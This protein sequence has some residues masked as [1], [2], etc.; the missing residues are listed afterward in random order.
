MC[1]TECLGHIIR[2][3]FKLSLGRFESHLDAARPKKLKGIP[4][5]AVTKDTYL[6]MQNLLI[7]LRLGYSISTGDQ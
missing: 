4:P 3:V 1:D 5:S 2:P 7:L 6:D